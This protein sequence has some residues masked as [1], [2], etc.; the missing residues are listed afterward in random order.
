MPL[1]QINR[2]GYADKY[3]LDGKPITQVGI[4]FSS[5]ERNIIDWH[6]ETLS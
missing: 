3:A 1:D 2:K 5:K 6:S 4:V